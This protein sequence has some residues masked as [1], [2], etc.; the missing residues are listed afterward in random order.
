M[1][2]N[3]VS[4]EMVSSSIEIIIKKLA[5]KKALSYVY[6]SVSL[7]AHARGFVHIKEEHSLSMGPH[8]GNMRM[9][10]LA[11][12]M[13][14]LVY[15]FFILFVALDNYRH[16]ECMRAFIIVALMAARSS[17]RLLE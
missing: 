17:F 5:C 9:Q 7:N 1:G 15:A 4:K 14:A 13:P 2:I 6:K 10:R 8:I 16:D 12:L 11:R 3:Y